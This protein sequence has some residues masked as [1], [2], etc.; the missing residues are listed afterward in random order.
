MLITRFLLAIYFVLPAE[1]SVF[2]QTFNDMNAKPATEAPEK[3]ELPGVSQIAAD[4]GGYA[5]APLGEAQHP[6]LLA[7]YRKRPAW[8][9]AGVDY[10]TGY[11]QSVSLSD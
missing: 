4:D 11:P 3:V 2:G 9:V 7:R 8:N 6:R 5:D 10:A 1:S